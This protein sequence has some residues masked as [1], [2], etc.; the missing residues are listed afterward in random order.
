MDS[1]GDLEEK[2]QLLVEASATLLA[3]VPDNPCPAVLGLVTRFTD[4]DACAIWRL[5]PQ[6]GIWQI[7]ESI[8]LSADFTKI[9]CTLSEGP[10]PT[11]ERTEQYESEG[12]RGLVALP[13]N[14]PAQQYLLALYYRSSRELSATDTRFA[15]GLANLAAAALRSWELLREREQ[16]QLMLELGVRALR[17]Q[18]ERLNLAMQAGNLGFWEWNPATG[19][20][21]CS[22]Q[23]TAILGFQPGE[24][25]HR[26]TTF[27]STIHAQDRDLFEEAVARARNRRTRFEEEV[28]VCDCAD[29]ERWIAFSG[30]AIGDEAGNPVRVVGV[31]IDVT[32]RRLL[33]MR[34]RE[35]HKRESVGLLAAGVAHD[36]NNLLTG[37][38]GNASLAGE[39][40]SGSQT[41]R[42]MLDNVIDASR[43]AAEL[44]RQLLAYSGQGKYVIAPVNLCGM[45]R[46]IADL[47]EAS[48][49]K[50]I[51]LSLEIPETLPVVEADAAQMQQVLLNLVINAAEAIGEESGSVIVRMGQISNGQSGEERQ[52]F[53]EVSDTGCGMDTATQER[54]FDPF[55][56]T[57]FTGR[58]LGLAA[59][60][61]IVRG[62][63]GT[64]TVTSEPGK[65]STFRVVLPAVRDQ[66]S[67][68][69]VAGNSAA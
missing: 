37:I 12:I 33:E 51:R 22:D 8:G 6:G 57:K 21:F 35:A 48:V 54:I 53:M 36:F 10:S 49:P 2:L 19:R 9:S 44:T 1:L 31:G 50:R 46:E 58:G 38:M 69:N 26:Y 28:R 61:G 41:V 65:G 39:L 5:D 27:L 43:R 42:A 63:R 59:V 52:V 30:K 40:M 62:H 4:A 45:V 60:S 55:F 66:Y 47:I 20:V 29:S 13:L 68:G 17:D 15:S 32:E 23:M 25:D 18:E 24:F 67:C 11:F 3:A 64:I 16:N 34:L 7:T 14:V 56:T